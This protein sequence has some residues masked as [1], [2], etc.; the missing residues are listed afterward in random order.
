MNHEFRYD[1][2]ADRLSIKL[3][4]EKS[5]DNPRAEALRHMRRLPRPLKS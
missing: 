5:T 4:K 1:P 2:A 3:V